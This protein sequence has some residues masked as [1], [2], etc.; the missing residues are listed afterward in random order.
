M[1]PHKTP[2]V[3]R[4]VALV[5]ATAA[6]AALALAA[7]PQAAASATPL[8]AAPAAPGVDARDFGVKCDGS[9]NDR[10]PFA[11]A[12]T[13]IAG[14]GGGRLTLP[15]GDCNLE[16]SPGRISMNI[17]SNVTVAGAG[18]QTRLLWS[19]EGGMDYSEV[20][21]V[22]GQSIAVENL[23]IVRTGACNGVAFNVLGVR[24]FSLRGVSVTGGAAKFDE[25]VHG[26]VLNGGGP[27]TKLRFDR[28]T[29]RD[30][31]YGLFQPSPITT[32]VND[33]EVTRSVF[34]ANWATDLEFN[35]PEGTMTGIKV[36]RSTFRDN[37]SSAYGAGFGVGLANVQNAVVR[38]N[39]FSNYGFE[40]VHIEDRS[41]NIKVSRNVFRRAFTERLDWASHVFIVSGSRDIR[42][43][44]N[45]FDTAD[46]CN[47]IQAVFVNAGGVTA[48]KPDS[49]S[50]TR[51]KLLKGSTAALAYTEGIQGVAMHSNKI[52]P[53]G[54]NC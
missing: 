38:K 43:N 34:E 11:N 5:S 30:L 10:E 16:M 31:D 12:L 32:L 39:T 52:V 28:M 47:G 51:N 7:L 26:I 29:L 37:K 42:V 19:C 40:P 48:A 2:S 44:R 17:P 35:A 53:Q 41:A 18:S 24:G 50:I 22:S 33:V 14:Q 23:Q 54:G 13:A 27:N 21:R 20:F 4:I 15:A 49:V 9:N 36:V 1:S 25:W 46:N 6:T 45:T 8:A 3:R